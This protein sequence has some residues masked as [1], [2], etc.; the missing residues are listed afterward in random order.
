M[1]DTEGMQ[2]QRDKPPEGGP[3]DFA[4]ALHWKR[5][6][7]TLRGELVVKNV[8]AKTCRISGK[9]SIHPLDRHR[10]PLPVQNIVTLELRM[11]GYA[12]LGPGERAVAEARWAGWCGSPP[13]RHVRVEWPGGSLVV[14]AEGPHHPDCGGS[15][16]LTSS[17]WTRTL[18]GGDGSQRRS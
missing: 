15:E 8:G 2:P 18:G 11:P 9:P 12:V 3:D 14:K 13:S 7:T 16:S 6:G 10:K 1:P 17:W 4:M 5:D